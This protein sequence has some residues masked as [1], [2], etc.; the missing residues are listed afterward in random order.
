M[1]AGGAD[2]P[3]AASLTG[4]GQMPSRGLDCRGQALETPRRDSKR[5]SPEGWGRRWRER[6]GGDSFGKFVAP[7][8]M[9][10]SGSS[11]ASPGEIELGVVAW[12]GSAQDV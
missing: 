4:A 8:E 10:A 5:G 12:A 6:Y 7:A 2:G 9:P 1:A 3:R 11:R